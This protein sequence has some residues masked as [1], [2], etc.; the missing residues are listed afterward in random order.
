MTARLPGFEYQS[1]QLFR[2]KQFTGIKIAPYRGQF[3]FLLYGIT[4]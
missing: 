4:K 1:G 2:L 3:L